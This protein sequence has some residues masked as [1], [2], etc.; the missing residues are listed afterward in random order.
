[1]G[2]HVVK[3]GLTNDPAASVVVEGDTTDQGP[4]FAV[5]PYRFLGVEKSPLG[6]KVSLLGQWGARIS[7]DNVW[8]CDRRYCHAASGIT[9]KTRYHR[10]QL[11]VVHLARPNRH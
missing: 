7:F 11:V 6:Q 3:G 4:L 1:M 5:H 2:V 8:Q 9:L 10:R